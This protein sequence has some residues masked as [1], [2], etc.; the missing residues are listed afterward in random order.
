MKVVLFCGGQGLRLK[1]SVDGTPKPLIPIHGKP[2]L[3]HLM[4]IYDSFG[5][6]EFILCLGEQGQLIKDCFLNNLHETTSDFELDT[7]TGKRRSLGRDRR[8]WKVSLVDT[9]RES[10]LNERLR[11][12]RHLLN[13]N[14]PFLCNYAD[15]L[16]NCDINQMIDSHR[17]SRAAATFL[18]TKTQQSFHTVQFDEQDRVTS[19]VEMKQSEIWINA[20]FFVFSSDVFEFLEEG[21]EFC[22][23]FLGPM[24][25]QGKLNAIKHRGYFGCVDT[26]KDLQTIEKQCAQGNFPWLLRD[27]KIDQQ[28]HDKLD[29]AVGL[30]L[31]GGSS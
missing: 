1:T 31:V 16:A 22:D 17:E 5:H 19:F 10:S 14:E 4:D 15:G 28:E 21:D 23:D 29:D 26:F 18:V 7:A 20:G 2:I 8:N 3:L 13:E 30:K 24:A 25:E 9:G 6:N 11:R 27:L 12:V